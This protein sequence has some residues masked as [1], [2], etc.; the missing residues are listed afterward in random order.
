MIVELLMLRYA[1]G[2][3]GANFCFWLYFNLCNGSNCNDV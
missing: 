1:A 3:A 2:C